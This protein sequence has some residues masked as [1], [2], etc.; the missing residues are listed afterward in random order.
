MAKNK[1]IALLSDF[2]LQ[3]VYVGAIKGAIARIDPTLTVIDLTHDIPPQNL[4]AARFCLLEA[5]PYFPAGTVYIA[6]VDPGVG[7]QRRGA[8]I[9]VAGG[10]L[11]GPDNGIFS[12][13]LSTA[14]ALAAVELT[15]PNYW[16]SPF[17]STTFHGRDIFAPAGAFLA[18]GTP[19]HQLGNPIDP[20]TLVRL[21]LLEPQITAVGITGCIQY[22]DR[23][24]NLMT[25]IPAAAVAGKSWSVVVGDRLIPSSKTYSDVRLGEVIVLIGSHGWVEIAVNCGHAQSQLQLD[26]LAPVELIF[27]V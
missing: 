10:Y 24:G 11:V 23:F 27:F 25:N 1:I 15:N 12:G 8:A 13:I 14:P 4:A 5:Y 16:R 9:E 18:S 7:S 17:P 22:V 19:L 26:W 20:A 2:G 21:P 6:V 3:D